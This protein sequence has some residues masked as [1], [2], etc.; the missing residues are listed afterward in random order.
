MGGR[1]NDVVTR[2]AGQ[3]FGLQRVVAVVDVIADLDAGFLFET[4]NGV[5]SRV[6][7]PVVDVDDLVLRDRRRCRC[8]DQ[9]R[10]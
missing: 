3:Q 4:R 10:A 2:L 1:D 6:F 9:H 8:R 7:G 5:R